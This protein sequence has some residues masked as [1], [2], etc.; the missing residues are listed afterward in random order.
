M[1]LEQLNVDVGEAF[2]LEYA[3]SLMYSKS[4]WQ[5]CIIMICFRVGTDDAHVG[6]ASFSLS[7]LRPL[8]FRNGSRRLR[9]VGAP[10]RVD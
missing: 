7:R 5:V 8:L 6:V 2:I 9:R 1:R 4:L 3:H 10:S